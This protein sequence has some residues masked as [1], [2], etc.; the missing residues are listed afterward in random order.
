VATDPNRPE[1]LLSVRTEIEAAAIV[2]ALAGHDIGAFAVGGYTAGFRAE[3]PGDVR[4]MVK[5]ADLDRARQALAEIQ[6]SKDAP[7]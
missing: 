3:A 1:P 6:Q 2:T 7:P 4:V 5:H